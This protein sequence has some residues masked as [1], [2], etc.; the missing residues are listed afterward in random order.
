MKTISI[1]T[2]NITS[3]KNNKFVYKFP[4]DVELKGKQ[5]GLASLSMFY[6]MFN[7]S[8]EKNN[9]TVQY[10]FQGTTYTIT[11]PNMIAEVSDLQAYMFYVFRT[12]NHYLNHQNGTILYPVELFI[13]PAQYAVV[14]SVNTFP[15]SANTDY[16]A[17]SN[18]HY[19]FSAQNNIP[20]FMMVANTNFH[21][22]IGFP[23]DYN[24]STYASG[25][26][27]VRTH[28]STTAPVLNPDSNLIVVVDNLINNEYSIPNGILHSFGINVAP[29]TQIIEKPNE[30]AY[31]DILPGS[32][33]EIQLR[34][35]NADTLQDVSIRDPEISI[36]LLIK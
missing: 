17:S 22:L 20:N 12:N 18:T 5:I 32:Y 36:M 6:S 7:I 29:S 35:L 2:K 21:K 16:V 1:T 4:S 14:I 9:N 3:T 33:R 13:D 31:V 11:F 23:S 26:G 34:I 27:G 25:Q 30:I 19:T 8:Q 10:V 28:L 24:N 15:A